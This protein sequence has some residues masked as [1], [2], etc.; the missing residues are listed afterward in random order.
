MEKEIKEKGNGNSNYETT[1][2]IIKNLEF[3]TEVKEEDKG[4]VRGIV[5]SSGFFSEEEVQIAVD[6][7]CERLKNGES[8]GY[9]FLFAE[10]NGKTIGYTCYGR[11]PG[12]VCSYDLYWIAVREEYRRKGIGR[13]L[14]ERTEELISSM[15]GCRIYIET[16]S[17]R[18]YDS[19]RMFYK[20]CMYLEEAI[21]KDF[22]SP[23]DDKII[24]VK[25]LKKY[26]S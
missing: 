20:R 13:I 7:V 2:K 6:L 24:Y 22:Y 9:H 14:L 1:E 3:R 21:L 19:T 16:S 17:R 26:L 23:G 5:T 25:A 10:L 12:T 4:V 15:G 8:S 11:I 18:L